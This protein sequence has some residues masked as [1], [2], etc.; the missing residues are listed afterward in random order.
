MVSTAAGP[1]TAAA[2]DVTD[3]SRA[4]CRPSGTAAASC[5]LGVAVVGVVSGASAGA[6]LA[7]PSTAVTVGVAAVELGVPTAMACGGTGIGEPGASA[8]DDGVSGGLA[9]FFIFAVAVG[10]PTA[11]VRAGAGDVGA[12][13]RSDGI[14]DVF[15]G[16]FLAVS[17]EN[18]D[19]TT[20]SVHNNVTRNELKRILAPMMYVRHLLYV[21][22]K[23]EA[24]ACACCSRWTLDTPVS[25]AL[26]SGPSTNGTGVCLTGF[27]GFTGVTGDGMGA[28]IGCG[29]AIGAG[30]AMG[31]GAE[32]S[33]G[34]DIDAQRG[35]S[36]IFATSS[37]FAIS[38]AVLL[39]FTD[40]CSRQSS[41][42]SGSK[43]LQDDVDIPC[44]AESCLPPHSIAAALCRC[45]RAPLPT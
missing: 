40:T 33:A 43:Q 23:A 31:A 11:V 19:D 20:G 17:F 38:A 35:V 10:V 39:A 30:A 42:K 8:R 36:I 29:A 28:G 5:P 6:A 15:A 25:L 9:V 26:S 45:A 12:S 7:V 4:V 1:A 3:V 24:A 27:T 37:R 18:T 21:S 34:A 32:I 41:A 16:S 14:V 13:T 2:G 22:T 44:H